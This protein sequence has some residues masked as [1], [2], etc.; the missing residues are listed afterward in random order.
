MTKAIARY[1][2][3]RSPDRVRQGKDPSW[4]SIV[5]ASRVEG[6]SGGLSRR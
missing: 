4:N 6:R 3:S 1:Q 2:Y 5:T